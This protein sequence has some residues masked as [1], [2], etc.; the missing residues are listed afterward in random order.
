MSIS[1]LKRFGFSDK[2]AAIYLALLR[3]GPSSVRKLAEMSGFNRGV[4]YDALKWLQEQKLVD[5]YEKENKQCFVAEDPEKLGRLVAEQ[6]NELKEAG[7]NLQEVIPELKSLYNKG[8]E[9]PISRYFEKDKLHTI[10]EDVLRSCEETG[11]LCYRI[12]SAVGIREY[13][14]DSFATFSDVRIGKG[15]AVKVIALGEGGELRGLDERKWLPVESK[16][17]TYIIIYP[18]KT[19]YISLN[20]K[21][22]PV[23]VVIENDGVCE[24]QKV[25]FDALW[26]SL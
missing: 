25:I 5:F 14:Y 11:D 12:F 1:I 21:K 8:G 2:N 19:A 24:T 15:I 22:E 9:Q 4:V 13:L 6:E 18:G 26:K 20:A 7:K 3:L 17:P 16:T 10:L 23:G